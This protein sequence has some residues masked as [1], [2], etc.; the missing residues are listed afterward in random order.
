MLVIR[1]ES[2]ATK[3]GV[4]LSGFRKIALYDSESNPTEKSQYLEMEFSIP[5]G[6]VISEKFLK[7]I[8]ELH[9]REIWKEEKGTHDELRKDEDEY[10]KYCFVR[11]WDDDSLDKRT[12]GIKHM[13]D[14]DKN[15]YGILL[16]PDKK[17]RRKDP[18]TGTIIYFGREELLGLPYAY[19]RVKDEEYNG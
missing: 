1:N 15:K 17:K 4:F 19:T 12:L 5:E 16:E 6:L 2:P 13:K 14:K 8:N 9:A 11:G 18:D 3:R 10:P 7:E